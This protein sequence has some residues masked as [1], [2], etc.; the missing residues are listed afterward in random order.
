MQIPSTWAE[1]QEEQKKHL[2]YDDDGNEYWEVEKILD[3]KF[4]SYDKRNKYMVKWIGWPE[5]DA[6]WE[7][8]ENL[9]SAYELVEKFEKEMIQKKKKG[10]RGKKLHNKENNEASKSVEVVERQK[11]SESYEEDKPKK[12]IKTAFLSKNFDKANVAEEDAKVLE[13]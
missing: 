3:K 9:M 4:H 10:K 1:L 13:G 8:L 11:S 2:H 5:E 12:K 6:T 7:P